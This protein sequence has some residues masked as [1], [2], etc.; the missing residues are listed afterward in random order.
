MVACSNLQV[1]SLLQTYFSTIQFV[2][3][4][5]QLNR[6]SSLKWYTTACSREITFFWNNINPPFKCEQRIS[7]L[8]SSGATMIPN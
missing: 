5:F 2:V 6:I 8:S 4:D 7:P 3:H 1:D